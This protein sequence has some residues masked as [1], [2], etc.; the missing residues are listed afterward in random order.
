VN[1]RL[2]AATATAP[3]KRANFDFRVDFFMSQIF[4]S[5][6]EVVWSV[7]LGSVPIEAAPPFAL[8]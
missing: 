2:N 1:E 7:Y 3:R 8:G 4:F 6:I 5:W